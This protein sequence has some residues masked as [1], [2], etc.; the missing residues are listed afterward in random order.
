MPHEMTTKLFEEMANLRLKRTTDNSKITL[1]QINS[2]FPK[3]KYSAL[4][5]GLWRIKELEE[6]NAKK[7][8]RIKVHSLSLVERKKKKSNQIMEDEDFRPLLDA[9]PCWC[10]TTYNVSNLCDHSRTLPSSFAQT[11]PFRLPF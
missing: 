11:P 3:D 7:V 9:F 5:Y 4:A 2:R 10:V 8:R 6:A 1:E